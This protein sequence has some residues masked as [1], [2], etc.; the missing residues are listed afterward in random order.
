MATLG[1]RATSFG[2]V[3]DDYDR[4]R[5]G[6][7]EAALGWLLP[8]DCR[9]AAD[10][11]AGTGLFTR[12][13]AGRVDEV[14]AVEPDQRMRRVLRDRSSGTHVVGGRAESLPFR[15]GSLD[16]ACAS[17]SWHWVDPARAVPEVARVLR[18]GGRLALIWTSRDREVDWV[19][20][21]DRLR[22][23]PD[24][25]PDHQVAA[26]RRP[27][28]VDLPEDAPL[29]DVTTASF[30]FTRRMSLDD[31]VRW[32]GTYSGMLTTPEDER[33]AGLQRARDALA[34]RFGPDALID[35]PMRSWCWRA[36][37]APR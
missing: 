4:V 32:L 10:L 7:P 18:D 9:R 12:A 20:G 31:V 35:V 27:R 13:L 36:D 29:V 23:A 11:G 14:V 25:E 26:Q 8:A 2:R 28:V 21:L 3:A 17:S 33:V 5:P 15:D 22:T 16:A 34:D 19:R 37:R 24:R 1:E 30:T 6:P